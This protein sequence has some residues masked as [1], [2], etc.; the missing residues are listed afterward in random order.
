VEHESDPESTASLAFEVEPVW[1]VRS[2]D[3]IAP[4]VWRDKWIKRL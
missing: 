4:I 1:Q 3:R 2:E